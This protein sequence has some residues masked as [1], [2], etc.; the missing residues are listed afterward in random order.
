MDDFSNLHVFQ[1]KLGYFFR[2]RGLL[3][4]AL[5]HASYAHENGLAES[6]ERLEFLG[7]SVLGMVVARVLYES[8]PD[9]TEGELTRDRVEFV[10]R[11]AL[12]R[13]AESLDVE[14]VLLK[15]KSLKPAPPSVFADAMEAV[16]GAV[17][18]DG[19]HDAATRTIRRYL[20]GLGTSQMNSIK[21]LKNGGAWDA[22]SKLQV[23]LQSEEM[24]LPR[25]EVLS[26]TGPS[27]APSFHVRVFAAGKT[28]SG[29][30]ASRKAAELAAAA[31]ALEEIG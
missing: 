5:C 12:V 24:G 27:H 23:R 1:E 19:G 30:G 22:K 25:Y 16:L 18:L 29:R 8:C 15:G 14:S 17:Y 26:V 6:N 21:G 28:W 9:A 4:T 2:D 7:D 31:A 10:C 11:D 20:F 13:W 3:A